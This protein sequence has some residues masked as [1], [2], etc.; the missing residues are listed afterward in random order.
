MTN[1]STRRG[2][3]K[4]TEK[5]RALL[6]AS[7][8]LFLINGYDKTSMDA[9]SNEAGV[10]KQTLYSHFANKDQLFRACIT[11]KVEDH[12]LDL[13]WADNATPI[14]ETMTRFGVMLIGLF[15]D[16]KVLAMYR[17]LMAESEHHPQLC[18]A[19]HEAGPLATK[20]LLANY[21][22]EQAERGRLNIDD[23]LEAAELFVSVIERNMLVKKLLGVRD[24]PSPHDLEAFVR[25]RVR[26]FLNAQTP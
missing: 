13:S 19:F 3:P 15:N 20:R 16:P 22:T 12:G 9:V 23:P 11:A 7:A 1:S 14:E 26:W 17:L 5:R 8:A 2:R 10:S 25:K 18:Q 21:L 24:T 6:D 4:S